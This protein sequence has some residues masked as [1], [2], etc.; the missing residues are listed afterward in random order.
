MK[1]NVVIKDKCL[2]VHAAE[3]VQDIQW[4]CNSAQLR[5]D[6]NCGVHLGKLPLTCNFPVPIPDHASFHNNRFLR[7]QPSGCSIEG[8][9]S[10]FVYNDP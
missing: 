4:L 1:F 2:T 10:G 8:W 3:G 6:D 5:Y 9:E 7:R